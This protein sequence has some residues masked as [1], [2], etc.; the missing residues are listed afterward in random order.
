MNDTLLTHYHQFLKEYLTFR[1]FDPRDVNEMVAK[2]GFK[3]VKE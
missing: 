2:V 1:V 3:V